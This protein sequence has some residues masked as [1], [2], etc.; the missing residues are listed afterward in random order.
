MCEKFQNHD[1]HTQMLHRKLATSHALSY[2]ESIIDT[3]KDLKLQVATNHHSSSPDRYIL[4]LYNYSYVAY[5]LLEGRM[6]LADCK[7]SKT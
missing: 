5:I 6:A 1:V 3:T 7:E 4:T 2:S